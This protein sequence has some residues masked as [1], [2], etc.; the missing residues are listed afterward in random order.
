[1]SHTRNAR[2]RNLHASPL[3][4][5]PFRGCLRSFRNISARTQHISARHKD[6][7]LQDKLGPNEPGDVSRSPS[8]NDPNT[9]YYPNA[10]PPRTPST[11]MQNILTPS[12][13]QL[14]GHREPFDPITEDFD[15][16]HTPCTPT[17]A[18]PASPPIHSLLGSPFESVGSPFRSQ[19]D[20]DLGE[21]QMR[22]PSLFRFN[23]PRSPQSD[24]GTEAGPNADQGSRPCPPSRQLHPVECD[25]AQGHQNTGP[26]VKT[27][28]TDIDGATSL[29]LHPL[30][31]TNIAL[32]CRPAM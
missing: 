8:V 20:F 13:T 28:H 14:A 19:P 18:N 5:C 17:P 7:S 6:P 32:I 23:S 4:K 27:F 15:Y 2:I 31:F 10:S 30:L 29:I 1:M 22:S 3:I 25:H 21:D 11:L 9:D 16:S 12:P 26:T 24:P